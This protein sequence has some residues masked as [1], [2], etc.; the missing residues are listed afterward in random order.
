MTDA[1]IADGGGLA[2]LHR[3]KEMIA[4]GTAA[5]LVMG[6]VHPALARCRPTKASGSKLGDLP[7][8]RRIDL[9]GCRW[10]DQNSD[11]KDNDAQHE[12]NSERSSPRSRLPSTLGWC[13]RR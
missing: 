10:N 8:I 13:H 12:C 2:R 1:V 6:R 5:L 7:T 3:L 11:G 4:E 9:G